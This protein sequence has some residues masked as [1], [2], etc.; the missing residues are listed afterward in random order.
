[1]GVIASGHIALQIL[2]VLLLLLLLLPYSYFSYSYSLL[3]P[4]GKHY[5]GCF[6]LGTL[7]KGGIPLE[8]QNYM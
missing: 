7:A 2:L 5:D 4:L 1:M 6:S 8:K 3:L